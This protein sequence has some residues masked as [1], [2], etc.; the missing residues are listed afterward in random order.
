VPSLATIIRQTLRDADAEALAHLARSDGRPDW[1]TIIVLTTTALCL[2]VQEYIF[3]GSGVEAL[4]ALMEMVRLDGAAQ[5]LQKVALNDTNYEITSLTYWAVGRLITYVLI[6]LL[7]M[8]LMLREPV[9]HFGIS[10]KGCLSS[11][12]LYAGMFAI[13]FPAVYFF[14]HTDS[15]QESYPFYELN[16]GEGLWPRFWCWE[17]LYATQ[18][19]ALEFF[20]RG[21]LLHGV[22]HRAGGMAIFVMMVPYCM[23][24][25]GKPMPETLGAIGAGIILGFMSLK[26]RSIWLGALL[27]I[28][29]AWSMDFLALANRSAS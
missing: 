21:F 5:W 12:L 11:L 23:L 7:V 18:F 3:A 28:A 1:R 8:R 9:R 16:P 29:V 25:F 27:H 6:P 26:T 4:P 22:R 2:T 17:L 14:S 24:H 20:F 13:M 15:F 10:T 19:I